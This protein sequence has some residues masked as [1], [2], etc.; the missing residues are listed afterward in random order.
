MLF[1]QGFRPG[2]RRA[3]QPTP[4]PSTGVC[5]A[6]SCRGSAGALACQF[7]AAA[8]LGHASAWQGNALV[9]VA[10]FTA[11]A[12]IESPRPALVAEGGRIHLYYLLPTGNIYH[13][14]S[15]DGGAT[16]GGAT[17]LYSG[18]DAEGDVSACHFAAANVHLVHFTV[19]TD[20]LRL[21][22]AS[23]LGSGAWNVWSVHGDA[24]GWVAAGVMATGARS[25]TLLAWARTSGPYAHHLGVL[26]CSVTAAGAL[27]ACDASVETTWLVSGDTAIRPARHAVGRGLGGWLHSCQEQSA[28]RAYLCVGAIDADSGAPEEPMPVTA[29][30]LGTA[31]LE[32]HFA[33]LD[34][35]AQ[36]LLVG[37]AAVFASSHLVNGAA[38]DVEVDGDAV[39]GYRYA[40]R[41]GEGGTLAM[42]VAPGSALAQARAGWLLWL[43]RRCTKGDDSGAVTL[44]FRVVRVERQPDG[45]RLVAL[46]ALGLLA[47]TLA[48]RPLQFAPEPFTLA[49]AVERLAAWAGLGANCDDLSGAAPLMQW[50]G[51]EDGLRAL[52]ALLRAQPVGI[53]SRCSAGE[54]PTIIVGPRAATSLEAFGA[55]GHPLV[56]HVRVEETRSPRLVV[57]HGVAVR[58]APEEGEEWALAAAAAADPCVRAQ[59]L[60]VLNRNL[61]GAAQLAE[62]EALRTAAAHATAAGWID[63]QAHLALEP[64]DCATVEGDEVY[65]QQIVEN[66][67][68][69]RLVQRVVYGR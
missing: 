69:R 36:S 65:V 38:D 51:G 53:R 2:T 7:V 18:G 19:R 13:R 40:V 21:R 45:V 14:Q 23:R 8:E 42:V 39:I 43:T 27:E 50:S 1:R 17:A 62:A 49:R 9:T 41:A 29:T 4:W 61:D 55:D 24:R 15:S 67:E 37:L 44:G 28:G 30:L 63:I 31:P 6:P 26:H 46:D 25:A 60:Y 22:C 68:R 35:G 64:E 56:A 59:P 3:L 33:P 52:R 32:R 66:W 58:G 10:S 16:W 5:C 57:V 34:L 48:R 12:G 54:R 11:A 20:V 47:A